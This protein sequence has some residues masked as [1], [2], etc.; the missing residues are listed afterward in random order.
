MQRFTKYEHCSVPQTK[1]VP[2]KPHIRD[3][4]Q[5]S[6]DFSYSPTFTDHEKGGTCYRAG[7]VRVRIDRGR[8]AFG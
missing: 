2:I 7:T 8:H 4:Q 5:D 3:K 1:L 6:F